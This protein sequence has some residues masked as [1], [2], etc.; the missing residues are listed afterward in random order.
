MNAHIKTVIFWALLTVFWALPQAVRGDEVAPTAAETAAM[1]KRQVGERWYGIYVMGR[2]V[3]WQRETW[4]SEPGRFCTNLEFELRMA[5][6]MAV[7]RISMKESSCFQDDKPFYAVELASDRD[8][9]GKLVHIKGKL[10]GEQMVLSIDTSNQV[11][12]TSVPAHWETMTD[13]LPWAAI[14]RMK[15]SDLTRAYTHDELTGKRRWQTF[16][17]KGSTRKTIMGKEQTVHQGLLQDEVGLKLD[18]LLSEEGIILEGSVGP[19]MRIVL[20]DKETAQ[21]TE[22]QLLDFYSNSFVEATGKIDYARVHLIRKMQVKLAGQSKVEIADSPRQVIDAQGD[23][24]LVVTVSACPTLKGEA[25]GEEYSRCSADLPCDLPAFKKQAATITRKA[26]TP[27]AR[28]RLI[29]KWIHSNF[30]YTLGSGS[31]TADQIL[32]EKKGDCTEYSKAFVLLARAA[33]LTARQVSGVALSSDSPPSFG[34]HAWAEVW[35]PKKGWVAFDPTWGHHPVDASH[36]VLD[37]EEGLGMAMHLGTLS[38]DIKGVDYAD[39]K[40]GLVCD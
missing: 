23:K 25:P 29:S 11:R 37:L 40:R 5:F 31:G 17:L 34:Y 36:V 3:G 26:R 8:E 21:D 33:G 9:D 19:N 28:A 24:H 38:I 39:D 7:T 15:P 18:M 20:E 27:V 32:K 12:T 4:T 10:E 14:E 6:L 2:K 1:A 13:A 35:I 30:K 16:T 22:K